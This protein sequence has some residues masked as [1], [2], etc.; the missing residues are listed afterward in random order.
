PVV[1]IDLHDLHRVDAVIDRNQIVGR[2]AVFRVRVDLFVSPDLTA[3]REDDDGFHSGHD[4]V[5]AGVEDADR[6]APAQ[7]HAD[8]AFVDGPERPSDHDH[9][10][11]DG[12]DDEWNHRKR[13]A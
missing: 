2:L 9:D 7:F 5:D 10:D 8:V 13:E 3:G 4:D 6:L 12:A 1:A 11:D